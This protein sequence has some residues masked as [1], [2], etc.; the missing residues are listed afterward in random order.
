M[1]TAGWNWRAPGRQ[2]GCCLDAQKA[3]RV[4]RKNTALFL[5]YEAVSIGPSSV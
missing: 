3:L 1:S 4:R 5:E 2:G